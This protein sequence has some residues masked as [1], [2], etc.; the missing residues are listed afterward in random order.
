[1]ND[2]K[3]ES[4]TE[5]NQD[6]G[7]PN[8]RAGRDEEKKEMELKKLL[9]AKEEETKDLKNKLLYLQADFENFRKRKEKESAELRKMA[10]IDFMKGLLP[11]LDDFEAMEKNLKDAGHEVLVNGLLALKKNFYETLARMGLREIEMKEFDPNLH[12]VEAV[13]PADADNKIVEIVR[14]G[15]T[16]NGMVLRPARVIVGKK[17]EEQRSKPDAGS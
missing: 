13:V 11:V 12:E 17:A 3:T 16:V 8:D 9:E 10:L 7:E 2:K 1:M 14:K 15:Y 5:R 6:N 4:D